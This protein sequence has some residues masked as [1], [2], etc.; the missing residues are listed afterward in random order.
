M[1]D[2]VKPIPA[3][4]DLRQKQ[5]L[6]GTKAGAMQFITLTPMSNIS[7]V[8]EYNKEWSEFYDADVYMYKK[9]IF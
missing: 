7:R 3:I 8:Q 1:L 5:Q 9:K 2:S 6:I 4:E